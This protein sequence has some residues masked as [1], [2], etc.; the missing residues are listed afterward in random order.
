MHQSFGLC[1]I[2]SACPLLLSLTKTSFPLVYFIF[3]G[4]VKQLYPW[5]YPCFAWAVEKTYKLVSILNSKSRCNFS[6][7]SP[8]IYSFLLMKQCLQQLSGGA[9]TFRRS[10]LW[11]FRE[12][13]S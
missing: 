9:N 7:Y 12:L 6:Y 1:N 3:K 8:V 11:I 2:Y 4:Y 5:N 10:A 13:V